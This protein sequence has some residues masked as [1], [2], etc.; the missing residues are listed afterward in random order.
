MGA[1][2]QVISTHREL[3]IQTPALLLVVYEAQCGYYRAK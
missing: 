2:F 1:V 3:S